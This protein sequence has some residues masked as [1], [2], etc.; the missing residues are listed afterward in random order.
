MLLTN[1]TFAKN[2]KTPAYVQL[3]NFIKDQVHRREL[4]AGTRLPSIRKLAEALAISRTTVETAYSILTADGYLLSRP[5]RGYF[6]ADLTPEN[7]TAEDGR[8]LP[9]GAASAGSGSSVGAGPGNL[10]PDR[11]ARTGALLDQSSSDRNAVKYESYQ[12]GS[13]SQPLPAC[14]YNFANNYVD[15]DTF[16]AEL[17]RR[18][19]SRVLT[20]PQVLR[21]YGAYQGEP[22]LRRTLAEYSRQ[23][24]GV[25][26][27]PEQIV[28]GAGV[29]SL[30][31]ILAALLK[32]EISKQPG[33][34]SAVDRPAPLRPG[35]PGNNKGLEPSSPAAA[36]SL[37]SLA[38][39]LEE[40]GF[41]QA[42]EIFYRQ[43]WQVRH[44]T[45]EDLEADDC[46]ARQLPRVLYV[47]PSNPYKGRSLTPAQRLALLHWCHE[48]SGYVLE[49][50]YNGEFRYFSRPV[51][52]LQ[53][54]SDGENIIYLGSF[55]RLL[56]PSLRISY[57]VLPVRLLPAYARIGC[58]YNQTS[59]TIEQLALASF[60]DAGL[61]RRHVKRLRKIYSGKNTLLRRYLQQYLGD[62]VEVLA[63]ESGLHLHLKVHSALSSR[64][65]AEKALA[66]GVKVIP[67]R[68]TREVLLSFA[69]IDEDDIEPAVK[70]LAEAWFK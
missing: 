11:L 31:V 12:A 25:V 33:L 60:I 21:T 29:Q 65:L 70:I 53:G 52:S 5:Q 46:S 3:V 49:D 13:Q 24:R 38:L 55:S 68:G 22:D 62:K 63:Y 50:D 8:L 7:Q 36:V 20:N 10:G 14:R 32:D 58:L 19:L 34:D 35:N 56:L 64:Q 59:S 28:V 6:A 23:S 16:P 26:C 15:A 69:G 43:G 4:T 27:T 39:A 18:H 57:L 30:L 67:V 47:S 9:E 48:T 66:A 45:I 44:F 17:W 1:F 42:E 37:P 51:S 40:P 61:L 41:P 54:L 2:V